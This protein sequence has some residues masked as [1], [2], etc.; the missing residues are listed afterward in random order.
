MCCGLSLAAA[1][2]SGRRASRGHWLF[3]ELPT[4]EVLAA[5]AFRRFV[6]PEG[7]F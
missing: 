1:T 4:S 6:T 3:K 5:E 7:G 2:T